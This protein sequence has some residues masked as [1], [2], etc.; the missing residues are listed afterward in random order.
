VCDTPKILKPFGR[1]LGITSSMCV[2]VTNSATLRPIDVM[3]VP[4][5]HPFE[6]LPD[7]RPVPLDFGVLELE[8][9]DAYVEAVFRQDIDVLGPDTAVIVDQDEARLGPAFSKAFVVARPGDVVGIRARGVL[10]SGSVLQRNGL[11]FAQG[12]P[13]PYVIARFWPGLLVPHDYDSQYAIFGSSSNDL[14]DAPNAGA[15]DTEI[16]FPPGYCRVVHYSSNNAVAIKFFLSSSSGITLS[17]ANSG[18]GSRA[19]SPWEKV[20]FGGVTQYALRFSRRALG[21]N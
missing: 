18:S 4:V 10:S 2:S 3:R 13:A 5:C 19:I 20:V 17:L 16:G 12:T 9:H 8:C 14:A 6:K 15:G 1:R 7:G 11:V 21:G